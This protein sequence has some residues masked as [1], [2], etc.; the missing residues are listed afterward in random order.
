MW[1]EDQLPGWKN[2]TIWWEGNCLSQNN[3][4]NYNNNEKYIFLVEP[5]R[6]IN[7]V[8]CLSEQENLIVKLKWTD[9]PRGQHHISLHPSV[10]GINLCCVINQL[11]SAP[12]LMRNYVTRK[13]KKVGCEIEMNLPVCLVL[14]WTLS[15]RADDACKRLPCFS[16]GGWRHWINS[17]VGWRR[18]GLN[19][20]TCE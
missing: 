10:R 9:V 12:C 15:V 20:W 5:P 11:Q 1:P 16:T 19:D 6:G 2:H 18:Q 8:I 3:N 7:K 14:C 13:H 17:Q 4:N